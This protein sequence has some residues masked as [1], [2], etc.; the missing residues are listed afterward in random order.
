MREIRRWASA[1]EYA[2]RLPSP[3]PAGIGPEIRALAYTAMVGEPCPGDEVLLNVGALVKGLGTGGLAFVVAVP[4]RLPGDSDAPGHIVKARY[5]PQQ[6]MFMAIDEQDSPHHHL[7][8]DDAAWAGSLGGMPVV[9]AGLHSALPAILAGIRADRPHARVVYLMTDGGALPVAFSRSVA[10]LREAGWLA[11]TISVGQAFGG[12]HEAVTVHS[13]LVA[14][15]RALGADVAVVCQ[16]PGNV[17]TGTPWGFTGLAAGEA[18]NAAHTLRGRGVGA[19]RVS[20][21]DPRDRHH[22]ISHHSRTA[23]GRVCLAPADLP[24]ALP[25]N[26]AQRV[27]EEQVQEM[28]GAAPGTLRARPVDATGLLDALAGCPVPLSTMGR[29]LEADPEAFI[30]SAV[31]GRYAAALL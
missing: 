12:D 29:G 25:T 26:E 9:A 8:T 28:V 10:G 18:L 23:Y 15:R 2:V 24:H 22:G 1:V 3:D 14:A 17:G 19:L 4:D 31:A 30:A 6:Q 5:T 27:V 16:G 20:F 7:L 21:A 11:A 13:A